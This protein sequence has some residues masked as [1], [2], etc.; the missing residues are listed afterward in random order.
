M[1][2]LLFPLKPW[3]A[4]ADGIAIIG[5]QSGIPGREAAGGGL[6]QAATGCQSLLVPLEA[7]VRSR[8]SGFSC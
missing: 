8:G 6:I 2:T 3:P 5:C 4:Q 7:T 1:S